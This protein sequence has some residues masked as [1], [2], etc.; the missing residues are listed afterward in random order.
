MERAANG[1]AAIDGSMIGGETA[2]MEGSK[3]PNANDAMTP[4]PVGFA[5]IPPVALRRSRVMPFTLFL[6][7]CIK[8]DVGH[9]PVS[10]H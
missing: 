5:S 7:G 6:S 8:F 9:D 2:A 1:E 3:V 4:S 10:I